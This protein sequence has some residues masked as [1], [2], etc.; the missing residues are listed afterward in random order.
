MNKTPTPPPGPFTRGPGITPADRLIAWLDE[1][2]R[3]GEPRLVRLPL[4]LGRGQGPGFSLRGAHIGSAADAVEIRASDS[5]L[6]IGLADRAATQ[7]GQAP[8]CA[9]WVEG[10]WRGKED[11]GYRFDVVYVRDP[12]APEAMG[13]ADFVEVEAGR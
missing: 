4:V 1:Q 9:M 5:A 6:G 3:D 8:T 7:C 12:I 11:G 2:V 10:Y 13:S